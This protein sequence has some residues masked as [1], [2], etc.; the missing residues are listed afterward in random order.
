M[1]H[2]S[3]TSARRLSR[4]GVSDRLQRLVPS[5]YSYP[6]PAAGQRIERQRRLGYIV[7]AFGNSG[8]RRFGNAGKRAAGLQHRQVL[9][10]NLHFSGVGD[11]SWASDEGPEE[12]CKT[13]EASGSAGTLRRSSGARYRALERFFSFECVRRRRGF[14]HASWPGRSREEPDTMRTTATCGEI[15]NLHNMFAES[16]TIWT[17]NGARKPFD[18]VLFLGSDRYH[19]RWSPHSWLLDIDLEGRHTRKAD[20]RTFPHHR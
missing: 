9:P 20:V 19:L 5:P 4:P 2:G 10:G 18:V 7:F 3:A 11:I 16:S 13:H 6:R 1:R 8:G 15:K 14:R 12:H 17:R